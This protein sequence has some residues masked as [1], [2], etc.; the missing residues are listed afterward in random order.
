MGK[1]N[2]CQYCQKKHRAP[3]RMCP[4]CAGMEQGLSVRIGEKNATRRP[5]DVREVVATNERAWPCACFVKR[6]AK[7][8]LCAMCGGWVE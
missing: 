3:G 7:G 2:K 6:T 4:S 8:Q 5:L 1:L